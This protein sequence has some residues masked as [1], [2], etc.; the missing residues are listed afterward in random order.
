MSKAAKV[1]SAAQKFILP[2]PALSDGVLLVY[3]QGQKD[4]QGNSLEGKPI[5]D[6]QGNP[7]GDTGVV[8]RNWKDQTVQAVQGD[9]TGVIIFNEATESQAAELSAFVKQLAGTPS[10]LNHADIEAVLQFAAD[11]GLT[12]RYN[13]DRRFIQSKMTPV[14]NLGADEFGLYKR[15]DR[16]IC[17]AVRLDGRGYFKGPA[18][19]AQQYENGAVI[20]KQGENFRLIQCAEFERTYRLFDGK[21]AYASLLPLGVPG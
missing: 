9:G 1:I 14:G 15:D 12:D 13:S 4:K 19:T 10:M 18:A 7:I 6:W 2:I 3:P 21:R 11:L 16:D 20:V 17:H 5:T 8:F